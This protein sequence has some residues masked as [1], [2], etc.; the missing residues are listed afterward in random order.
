MKIPLTAVCAH[1]SLAILESQPFED[2]KD[3]VAT[4]V[5]GD[6]GSFRGKLIKLGDDLL[7]QLQVL[8]DTLIPNHVG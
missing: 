3:S 7:L 8:W 5:R 4:R 2:L 1:D 6:D